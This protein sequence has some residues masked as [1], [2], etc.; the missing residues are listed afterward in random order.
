MEIV[1]TDRCA[2]HPGRPAVDICPVCARPRCG[3]DAAAARG[4]G[5]EVCHGLSDART[6]VPAAPLELLVRGVLGANLTAVTWGFVESEYVQAGVFQYLAPLV[7][8]A[9]TGG[10]AL[11]A[12]GQPRGTDGTRM[13][14][15]AVA[16]ALLGCAFGFVLEGTYGPFSTS[17]DVLLPYLLAAAAC[18]LWTLP[19]K[20]A[21][22]ATSS[23]GQP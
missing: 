14:L 10:V 22:P 4:G 16:C 3:T 6:H 19:P 2:A 15:V 5:C 1:P 12:A 8:G 11:A 9:F 13:R 18:W 20:A 21:R 23:A 7:L 17:R